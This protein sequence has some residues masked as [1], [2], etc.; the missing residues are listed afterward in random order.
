[1]R[2]AEAGVHAAAALRAVQACG[3]ADAADHGVVVVD[4]ERVAVG[5]ERFAVNARVGELGGRFGVERVRQVEAP[6]EF[7]R[8]REHQLVVVRLVGAGGEI[9][10]HRA[11]AADHVGE[12]AGFAKPHAVGCKAVG[13]GVG[14]DAGHAGHVGVALRVAE[15]QAETGAVGGKRRVGTDLDLVELVLELTA[16]EAAAVI[17]GPDAGGAFGRADVAQ[18]LA[19]VVRLDAGNLH[20]GPHRKFGDADVVHVD[21]RLDVLE[22]AVFVERAGRFAEHVAGLELEIGVLEN[23]GTGLV[24]DSDHGGEFIEIARN[25]VVHGTAARDAVDQ[26]LVCVRGVFIAV[27]CNI[28]GRVGGGEVEAVA[29]AGQRAEIELRAR[30]GNVFGEGLRARRRARS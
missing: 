10:V 1:M 25:V 11:H 5:L 27:L 23:L 22:F 12:L 20:R 18:T 4:A 6:A 3:R 21:A 29:R 2:N 24:A 19:K 14:G 15:G 7:A 13:V 8:E 17:A 9:R 28:D 16:G 26:G 30:L